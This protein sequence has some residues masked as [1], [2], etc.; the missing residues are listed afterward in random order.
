MRQRRV[1]GHPY[2]RWLRLDRRI[3]Q[4][5][6]PRVP[7]PRLR[8]HC[9]RIDGESPWQCS[10]LLGRTLEC[11]R[12]QRGGGH[13]PA[14]QPQTAPEP[15]QHSRQPTRRQGVGRLRSTSAQMSLSRLTYRSGTG[16]YHASCPCDIAHDESVSRRSVWRRGAPAAVVAVVSVGSHG[17]PSTRVARSKMVAISLA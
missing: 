1:R 7:S 11:E 17:P 8:A 13:Q 15:A 3:G 16:P 9:R 4:R 5:Q 6:L 14:L 12:W 2:G 10:A